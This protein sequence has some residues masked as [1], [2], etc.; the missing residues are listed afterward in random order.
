MA[1][2]A[3]GLL[4]VLLFVFSVV[5]SSYAAGRIPS[6][7]A[8]ISVASLPPVLPA[9]GK[10][11]K[12]IVVSLQDSANNPSLAISPVLVNLRS[13][14]LNV[15]TL[16]LTVTIQ[17]GHDYVIATMTTSNIPGSTEITATSPG[18]LPGFDTVSTATPSGLASVLKVF[19]APIGIV[20]GGTG[21]VAIVLQD[22]T[23]LPAKSA[24]DVSI[25]LSLTTLGI[26]QL[27][28]TTLTIPAGQ[29]FA[30]VGYTASGSP[31]NS[32]TISAFATGY[33]SGQ[34][35]VKI[36]EA[37][38]AVSRVELVGIFQSGLSGSFVLPADGQSYDTLQVML[39]DA[40]GNP[41]SAP[42][43]G[44]SVQLSSSK[45]TIV[46]V[47]GTVIIPAGT[48]SVTTAL[49][50]GIQS[51]STNI[52]AF[53]QGYVGSFVT[54]SAVIPAPSRL[55]VYIDPS[56]KILT[57]LTSP[58]LAVQLQDD[59]GAPARA[60]QETSVLVTSSNSSVVQG[61]FTLNIS[62]G[63]DFVT[64]FL[65]TP[66]TGSTILT[67]SSSGLVSAKDIMVSVI[68]FPLT[69][70]LVSSS[71]AITLNGTSEITLTIDL[72]GQPLAGANVTWHVT[73]GDLG[74]AS[75]VTTSG[76]TATAAFHPLQTGPANITAVAFGPAIGQT[77]S[78]VFV[79]VNPVPK[80]PPLTIL[81]FI[82]LY[83]YLVVLPLVAL[84]FYLVYV[85]R[86]RRRKAK[87]ELEAAFQNVT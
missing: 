54:V 37:G 86:K 63:D 44:I 36:V 1:R 31:G 80:A 52:T 85:F 16:N 68:S 76:G 32:T 3:L 75:T 79:V 50:T 11:Y 67:A 83:G 66:G 5:G 74:Q 49:R 12:S 18:L 65:K 33:T 20:S 81:E 41:A 26:V 61:T 73:G 70:T 40:K 2:W 47:N 46:G 29:F 71:G 59:G 17:P 42:N 6:T 78:T 55:A 58:L 82:F 35:S 60:K 84:L 9:D 62:K 56:V 4:L 13:S 34:G 51:G 21:V 24:T 57:S 64:T 25:Q 15:G 19:P 69:V 28:S 53:S 7:P 27:A 14:Q 38:K 23:G 39:V 43:G 87:E 30:E 8:S 48:T 10:A 45:N 77:K 22:A 72:L